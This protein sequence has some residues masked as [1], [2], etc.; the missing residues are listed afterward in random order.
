M[1]DRESAVLEIFRTSLDVEVGGV[2]VD[3][4]EAGLLDSLGLIVLVAEIEDR[5][6]VRIPFETLEV[7]QF[8]TVASIARLVDTERPEAAP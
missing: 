7:D 5:F 3:V 2:D 8:R 4:I 6:E 1:T